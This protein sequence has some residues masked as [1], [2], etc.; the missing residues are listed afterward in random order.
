M[1]RIKKHTH[2]A[3]VV[4]LIAGIIFA[5]Q[6]NAQQSEI[7]MQSVFLY[8]FTRL[9]SWPADYQSGDFVMAVYGNTPMLEEIESLAA[10]RKAGT[11]NIVAKKFNSL[12]D[13]SKCHIIYIPSGESRNTTNIVNGLKEK[14]IKALIVT[15]SRNSTKSGAVVNF[16]IVDGKQRFELSQENAKIMG[17]T[18]G[19]EITRLAILVD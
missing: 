18:L 11:Q 16:T 3:K 6:L 19:G 2:L 7:R 9:V 1:I 4:F 13:L 17:L 15:D 14:N 8:N 10:T 12:N 5:L